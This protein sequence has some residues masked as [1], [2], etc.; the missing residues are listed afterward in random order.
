M[1]PW[2]VVFPYA[3]V[4]GVWKYNLSGIP[5]NLE[6]NILV[7]SPQSNEISVSCED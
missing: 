7:Y 1:N 2:D 4:E 3:K 5:G 6:T